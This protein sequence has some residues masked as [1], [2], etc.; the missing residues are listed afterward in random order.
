[1][2]FLIAADA[3]PPEVSSA[4][5]LMAELAEGLA[6]R[7][8]DVT[9]V[10]SYPSHYLAQGTQGKELPARER[11]ARVDVLRVKTLA[12]RK[13]NY[14]V[15][16]ISQL[17]LPF[18][19][20]W[21]VARTVRA[22]IDGIFVYSPP[23]PLGLLGVFVKRRY[24]ARFLLNLQDIFPQN[25]IDLGILNSKPFIAFFEWLEK[26]VYRRADLI[27]FHS[28]GGRKF[29]VERKRVPPEKIVTLYNWVDID[30]YQSPRRVTPPFRQ[31]FGLEGKYIFVF[32]GVF[33]PA[34][35]LEF[36]VSVAR[37]VRDIPDVVFLLVGGGS[38]KETIEGLVRE[39][40]LT[41][42]VVKPFISQDDYAAL[43]TEA[44]VGIV[45]LSPKNKT[46][47]VPGKLLGYLASGKPVAAFLNKESD[48]F[49]MIASAGCGY[50]Q[51]S[52]NPEGAAALVRKM[53]E[54]RS[55]LSK[56]GANGLRFAREHLSLES[57][58]K[59]IEELFEK[60]GA[61]SSD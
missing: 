16:G 8:H 6:G 37:E 17:L 15:R 4:A 29:L 12:Y 43:L 28:P 50:A 19:F 20:F 38:E 35:G 49:E 60:R 41:N 57:T 61:H 45:C 13:G 2:R 52:D 22:P 33:G 5:T 51:R 32:A 31:R 59:K 26:F 30:S 27:T 58:L 24:C 3:Y 48:G 34:Q 40:K 56:R 1:M 9:V 10:T 42:V 47:F 46:S 39:W 11:Q 18:L 55:K 36:L 14:I 23:L 21:K 54:E 53:Y 25:A 44:D 7:G